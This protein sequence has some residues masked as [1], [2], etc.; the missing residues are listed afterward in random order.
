[1]EPEIYALELAQR[2]AGPNLPLVIDVREPD[3]HQYCRIEG[4]QL[5]PLGEIATWAVSLD[6]Q[7]E[8]VFQCHS[9]FHSAQA[10]A[11]LQSLGFKHVY[12]LRGGIDAWSALVDPSVPRY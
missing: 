7:A 12:N 5:K 4:A 3:E 1:M 11:Y 8:I 9:G 6:P 2:I 10:T